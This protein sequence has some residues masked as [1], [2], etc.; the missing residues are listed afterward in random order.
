MELRDK[1]YE[2]IKLIFKED[3]HK[4]TDTKGRSYLSTTTLLHSY[5][6]KFDKSYWLHKKAKELG[7]VDKIVGEDCTIDEIL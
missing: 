2:E 5:A 4:Y 6:P 3:E 1:R 7:V